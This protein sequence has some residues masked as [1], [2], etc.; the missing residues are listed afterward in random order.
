[1]QTSVE[2]PR[3]QG[4]TLRG[5][6]HLPRGTTHPPLV[7][8]CHGFTGSRTESMFLF[9]RLSRFLE[10]KGIASLR[11]DFYG[12]GESDGEFGEMTFSG[13]CRDLETVL[14]W[15]RKE[16]QAG[17]GPVYL[18]GLSMGGAVVS[19]MAPRQKDLAGIILLN[20]ASNM[21]GFV[22]E[23]APDAARTISGAWD[24]MGLKIGKAF[25]NDL[26]RKDILGDA[27]GYEGKA[28]LVVGMKDQAVPPEWS[29]KYRQVYRTGLTVK[30]MKK[31][32]HTFMTLA[33]RAEL[34]RSVAGWIRGKGKA[35]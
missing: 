13:E 3:G 14:G 33:D 31:A 16:R 17:H 22:E 18:L 27:E 26:K 25:V 23:R 30:T 20:P 1:M 32:D 12:S 5:E 35:T 11:F 28:L 15:V 8:M 6:L 34:E 19:V 24:W 7:V 10:R 21:R 2:I 29:L 9:V 4:K